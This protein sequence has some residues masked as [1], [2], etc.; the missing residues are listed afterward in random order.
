MKILIVAP[1]LSGVDAIA[2]VRRVQQWHDVAV[3]YGT[4]TV[5]DIYRAVQEKAYDVL[6]FATH[7]GP[8][9]LAL[10]NGVILR[11][12][13][14]AQ[15]LR[16]RETTGV[17]FS[18]CN[19]GRIAS[20]CVR[21]GARWAVSAEIALPDAD[22]WKLAAAFY[23]H[24]RNEHAKDFVGAYVLADSG[25]GDYALHISPEWVQ[26]LQ[27]IAAA[28]MAAQSTA[29]PSISRAEALRWL[30]LAVAFAVALSWLIVR[31]GGG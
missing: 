30:G 14:V 15:F 22:A 5:D 9:G 19:T 21:H 10:S 23:S 18:A 29:M 17:F 4:V 27:R 24:Q 13:D 28:Y 7:G 16:L 25:D 8:E 3:L 6:H 1:E 11:A 31:L 20:Y 2:E 12:E 26:E